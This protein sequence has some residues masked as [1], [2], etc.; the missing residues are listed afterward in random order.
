MSTEQIHTVSAKTAY[1]R[2]SF[3]YSHLKVEWSTLH[4]KSERKAT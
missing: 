1:E 2:L 3:S 4:P